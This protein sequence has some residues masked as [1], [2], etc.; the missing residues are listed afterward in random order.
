VVPGAD[1]SAQDRQI[2][3]NKRIFSDWIFSFGYLKNNPTLFND[4]VRADALEMHAAWEK[5]DNP[6]S[7]YIPYFV[8]YQPVSDPGR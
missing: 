1:A 6:S 5:T 7:N 2:A 4:A 3:M 8:K